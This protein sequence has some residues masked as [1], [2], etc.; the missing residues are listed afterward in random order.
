MNYENSETTRFVKNHAT[1]YTKR[2]SDDEKLIVDSNAIFNQLSKEISNKGPNS[3]CQ[4]L[5]LDTLLKVVS[6]IINSETI[7]GLEYFMALLQHLNKNGLVNYQTIILKYLIDIRFKASLLSTPDPLIE[8]THLVL[9]YFK[10]IIET[11]PEFLNILFDYY[12]ELGNETMIELLLS[13]LKFDEV[14]TLEKIF[15][16]SIYSQ[17]ISKSRF[18]KNRT[19]NN[20][21]Y[22]DYKR[23]VVIT[24]E[25]I[26]N[27]INKCIKY[28]KY[29]YIDLLINKIIFH[30]SSQRQVLLSINESLDLS[31]FKFIID[32]D[33]EDLGEVLINLFDRDIMVL[34]LQLVIDSNDLGRLMWLIPNLD[35]FIDKHLDKDQLM[36][37]K[38][39]YINNKEERFQ[40]LN[41][42]LQVNTTLIEKI[43]QSLKKFGL[44]GK[45]L[46]YEKQFGIKADELLGERG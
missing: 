18:I 23:P 15:D 2:F 44:D 30:S 39:H 17:L 10:P 20:L 13:Y 35:I 46:N 16:K 42:G 43:Y 38:N 45:L 40:Q 31:Q 19:L 3:D 33:N 14:V 22:I 9:H 28:Q 26:F 34:L 27:I 37:L 32:N 41:K 12:D 36:A 4:M 6:Q 1:G 25:V 5:K 24:Q 11:N 29:Q 21:V 7:P 8:N